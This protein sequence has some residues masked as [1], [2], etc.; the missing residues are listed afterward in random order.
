MSH[1]HKPTEIGPNRTG[2]ATSPL[3]ARELIKAASRA[4]PNPTFEP[5]ELRKLHE[6]LCR[7]APPI[8]SM[9]PPG[10]L[11]GA[12][13]T[14][15]S[16]LKGERLNVFLDKLGARLA[17]E[18]GGVRLYGAL[19][20]K[21]AGSSQHHRDTGITREDVEEIRED[22]LRHYGIV[23]QA[24]VQCGG[25]PTALT[26]CGD[27]MGVEAMGLVQVLTDPRTTLTQC[28]DAVLV[29]ERA[30]YDGWEQIIL[31]ADGLGQEELANEFRVA[32]AEE[33]THVT[34]VRTWL[35]RALAGQAGIEPPAPAPPS[36]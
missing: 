24:I 11:K 27:L 28:L 23:H 15:I 18:R 22:E 8:G 12:A 2:I 32:F 26:P 29:A 5:S 1:P 3:D 6:E 9:P 21:L 31:L 4:V 36:P 34:K 13:K 25:D 16:A 19:L 10:T 17:F 14:V 35:T 30:D 7:E 20:A 33:G